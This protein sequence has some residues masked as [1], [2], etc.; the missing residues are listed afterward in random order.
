[1][2]KYSDAFSLLRSEKVNSST[3]DKDS[4]GNWRLRMAKAF[5]EDALSCLRLDYATKFYQL[6]ADVSMVMNCRDLQV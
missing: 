5:A 6:L 2:H 4:S 3:A 1:M